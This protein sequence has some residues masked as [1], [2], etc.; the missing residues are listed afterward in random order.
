MFS[1][2]DLTFHNNNFLPF[3]NLTADISAANIDKNKIVFICQVKEN[4]FQYYLSSDKLFFT[5]YKQFNY[6]ILVIKIIYYVNQKVKHFNKTM[7]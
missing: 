4:R 7:L 6:L 3:N 1:L 2:F 5:S